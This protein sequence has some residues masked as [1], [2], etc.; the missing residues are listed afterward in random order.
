MNLDLG[1]IL[2]QYLISFINLLIV[3]EYFQNI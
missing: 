2:L 3:G 1:N